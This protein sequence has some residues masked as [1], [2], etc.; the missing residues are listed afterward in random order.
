MIVPIILFSYVFEG[1]YYFMS[2]PIFFYK[3]T[4]VLPFTTGSAALVN[5][6]L[7]LIFIPTWGI[8]GA[9]YATAISSVFMAVVVYLVGRRLFDPSYDLGKILLL[10]VVLFVTGVL[11][12]YDGMSLSV[13]LL[14]TVIVFGF[15]GLSYFC[16]HE[17]FPAVVGKTIRWIKRG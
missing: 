3:K 6:V 5:I 4:K 12:R 2:K 11:I 8:M 9:A 7:N 16:F 17:Y 15:V 13:E 14:K 10:L 1:V